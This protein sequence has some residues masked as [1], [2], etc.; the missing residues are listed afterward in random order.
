VDERVEVRLL[1]ALVEPVGLPDAP[2]LPVGG[3]S[4]DSRKPSTSRRSSTA[5]T[6]SRG[7]LRISGGRRLPSEA[8]TSGAMK[9]WLACRPA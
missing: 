3:S 6:T 9:A 5:D 7:Q 2:Q 8:R 4:R 1:G